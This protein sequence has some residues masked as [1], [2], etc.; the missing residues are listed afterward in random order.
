MEHYQLRRGQRLPAVSYCQYNSRAHRFKPAPYLFQFGRRHLH[1]DTI[2]AC[3]RFLAH[4]LAFKTRDGRSVI[5]KPHLFRHAFATHALQVVG[6]PIDIVQALLN[7]KDVAVTYYYGKPTLTMVTD[8][9]EGLLDSMGRQVD[10]G[11]ALERAPE[12][13]QHMVSAAQQKVG[14]L[15]EVIGG[16]CVQPG[17]C[18]AKF[19]CIGCP[20]N[21]S[22]PSK[23]SQ[24]RR[25]VEWL[26][27]QRAA[28]IEDGLLPEAGRLEQ[29][30]RDAGTMLREMDLIEQYR[31]N[32]QREARFIP[33]ATLQ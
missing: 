9:A 28:A 32:E 14:A 25:R 10:I 8:A 4:G 6:L 16:T 7:Q 19:A 3:V 21:A 12:D 29:Q 2:A 33:I 15:A 31:R 1:Q 13:L 20:A 5:L 22:D 18:P 30:L 27:R 24:L 26:E 23:R 11:A 17:F